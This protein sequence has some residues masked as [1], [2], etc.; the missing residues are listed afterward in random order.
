MG[1]H[2]ACCPFNFFCRFLVTEVST[3]THLHT[4][5]W[6]CR[7]LGFGS[8]EIKKLKNHKTNNSNIVFGFATIAKQKHNEILFFSFGMVAKPK[9]IFELLVLWFFSFL[10]S[11]LPKPKNRQNHTVVCKRVCGVCVLNVFV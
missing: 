9:T 2:H 10:I 11:K 7:F 6:F 8:F 1:A 3:Q 5:V 4:T